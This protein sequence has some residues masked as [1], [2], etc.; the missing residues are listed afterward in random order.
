[1]NNQ[2]LQKQITAA[3]DFLVEKASQKQLV[4]FGDV[5]SLIGLNVNGLSEQDKGGYILTEVNK[6]LKDKNILLSA[7]VVNKE[8]MAPYAGF[9]PLAMEWELLSPNAKEDKK[10]FFG[11]KKCEKF[12]SS[13]NNL[14]I[15]VSIVGQALGLKR[16]LVRHSE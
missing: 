14:L 2:D 7:I 10:M 9:Y 12:L 4:Y 15:I 5:Y 6:E 1:M 16:F 11:Q 3:K 13:I 8:K